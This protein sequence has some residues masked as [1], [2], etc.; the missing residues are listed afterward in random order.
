[1]PRAPWT[2]TLAA[3]TSRVPAGPEQLCALAAQGDA[4]HSFQGQRVQ[5]EQ[6]VLQLPHAHHPPSWM[7]G[8]ATRCAIVGVL[9]T[10]LRFPF[11]DAAAATAHAP[12]APAA[13]NAT[14]LVGG[15]P[16]M[17]YCVYGDKGY[18]TED[19]G[20]ITAAFKKPT[21]GDLSAA[22]QHFNT[23]MSRQRVEMEHSLL[24]I[25]RSFS[26]LTPGER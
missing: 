17:Q 6:A 9:E 25:T 26:Y 22:E 8:G 18:V 21:H 12:A 15:V 16:T 3:P 20:C 23:A 14:I 10:H 11:I 4:R 5:H 19:S 2:S 13:P 24:C 1:M 7:A